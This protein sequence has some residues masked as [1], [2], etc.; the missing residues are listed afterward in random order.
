MEVYNANSLE[1]Y[2]NGYAFEDIN[3]NDLVETLGHQ[4]IVP[5]SWHYILLLIHYCTRKFFA[6]KSKS[7]KISKTNQ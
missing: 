5:M 1:L 2:I 4:Y 7:V 3:A 6:G